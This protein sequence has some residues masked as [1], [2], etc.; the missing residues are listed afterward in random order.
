MRTPSKLYSGAKN[1]LSSS[2]KQNVSY[3][4]L[5]IVLENI[6]QIKQKANYQISQLN[7]EKKR[8]GE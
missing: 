5:Q 4:E 8:L 6:Q 7:E 3:G 1:V 2:N